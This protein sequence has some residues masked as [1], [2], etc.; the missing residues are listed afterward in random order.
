MC[1]FSLRE[2]YGQ[3]Q[4]GSRRGTRGIK[5]AM[6]PQLEGEEVRV[7]GKAADATSISVQRKRKRRR[8]SQALASHVQ[9]EL[10]AVG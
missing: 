3:L 4:E 7:E 8:S 1:R 9:W 6:E 2:C 5:A 10:D